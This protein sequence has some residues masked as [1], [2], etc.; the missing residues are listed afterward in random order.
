VQRSIASGSQSHHTDW[1]RDS[2]KHAAREVSSTCVGGLVSLYV[3][4]SV[5]RH[6]NCASVRG[7][8]LAMSAGGMM[9]MGRCTSVEARG[10]QIGIGS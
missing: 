1:P 10:S 5:G 9:G 4:P 2:V 6:C 8:L 7:D 3:R